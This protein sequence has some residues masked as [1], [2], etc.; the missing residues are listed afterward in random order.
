MTSYNFGSSRW[1]STKL[2]PSC[3]DTTETIKKFFIYVLWS[4]NPFFF[5]FLRIWISWKAVGHRE[6]FV[7]SHLNMLLSWSNKL[8]S[9]FSFHHGSPKV[10]IYDQSK[11]TLPTAPRIYLQARRKFLRSW[12][13]K[14]VLDWTL[15][16]IYHSSKCWV[17]GVSQ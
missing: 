13:R 9:W 7:Q 12:L 16:L 11:K 1:V 15:M 3:E 17:L 2:L 6:G 14:F 10:W 4:K 5:V 8:H